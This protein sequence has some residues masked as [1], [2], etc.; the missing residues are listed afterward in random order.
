MNGV[1][2]IIAGALLLGNTAPAALTPDAIAAA[3]NYSAALDGAWLLI[4]ED[5]KTRLDQ[6]QARGDKS[7]KIYSGTKGFW[8]VAALAAQED[9]LLDL[10]ERIGATLP[11][12][13]SDPLKSRMTARHLLN[14]T[15]GIEPA[16]A[17]HHDGWA[18]RDRHSLNARV[19]APPGASF[20]Y[21]PASMQVFHALLARKLAARGRDTP[22]RYLERR[23]LG[24][25]G[26][27]KQRYLADRAGHPLLATGFTMTAAQWAR[28]GRLILAGGAPVLDNGM[29]EAFRGSHANPMFALGFWNN[30][31]AGVPGAREVDPED[32][33]ELKWQQQQWRNRC[34]CH[35][36]PNDLVAAIGSGGQRLYVVP[37]RELIV[38]RLGGPSKFSDQT[39]LRALFRK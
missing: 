18:N 20:I 34:L 37:S 4:I 21:G 16:F 39:F 8:T 27:G 26:L 5:G 17:L 13:A 9:G 14:M 10:D 33:L 29:D 35:S 30:R 2:M 31:L 7:R 19:I 3:A 25:L 12:W 32:L 23:V 22:A 38:V 24:P 1:M 11:E 6:R 36:A 15:A 28:M